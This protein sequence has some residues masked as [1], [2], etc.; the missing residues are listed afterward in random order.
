MSILETLNSSRQLLNEGCFS[1]EERQL[2]ADCMRDVAEEISQSQE[3]VR[4]L[5]KLNN[6]KQKLQSLIEQR[7]GVLTQ[8]S[9]MLQFSSSEYTHVRKLGINLAKKQMELIRGREALDGQIHELESLCST[10]VRDEVDSP[11]ELDK[12]REQVEMTEEKSSLPARFEQID[13]E[14]MSTIFEEE[15][16][17][18]DPAML[19]QDMIDVMINM[20]DARQDDDNDDDMPPSMINHTLESI[21]IE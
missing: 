15:E 5:K 2:V 18:P 4:T 1:D 3:T 13:E 16:K 20:G 11:R 8:L 19:T 14:P 10:R 12:K 17:L 7:H 21:V 6:Q 9:K